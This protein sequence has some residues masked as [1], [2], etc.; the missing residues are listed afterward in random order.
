MS[1]LFIVTAISGSDWN[2]GNTT[3]NFT[4]FGPNVTRSAEPI[5][6]SIIDDE[7]A[8]GTE[9]LICTILAGVVDSVRTEDP[10]QLTIDIADDDGEGGSVYRM[11]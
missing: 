4:T 11:C 5:T 6:V 2:V 1:F 9:S 8:E 10:K 7:F 3:L